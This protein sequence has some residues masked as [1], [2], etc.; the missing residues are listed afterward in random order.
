MAHSIGAGFN[1]NLLNGTLTLPSHAR[2]IEAGASVLLDTNGDCR[3]LAGISRYSL[4]LARAPFC[5]DEATQVHFARALASRL[6]AHVSSIGVHLTGALR[7]DLGFFGFGTAFQPTPENERAAARLLD[8]LTE[9]TQREVLLEN[10]NFYDSGPRAALR[11]LEAQERLTRGRNVALILDLAHLVMEAHN[12]GTDPQLLLGAVPLERVKIIH[13]SGIVQSPDGVLHDGHQLPVH[14]RVWSLLEQTLTLIEQPITVVIEH[15]DRRWDDAQPE[16]HS[17][18]ERL[19]RLVAAP[20]SPAVKAIDTDRVAI[21]Y[22]ANLVLPHRCRPLYDAI[23]K[24]AF[25]ALVL[26]WGADFLA[27]AKDI[28]ASFVMRPEEVPLFPGRVLDPADDFLQYAA[29][30]L[31]C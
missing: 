18:H 21:G 27:R 19:A 15:T 1:P 23:G 31:P 24:E 6:P 16:F 7:R 17:D 25:K 11:V 5:E 22:M 26:S 2:Y 13:L 29:R 14:A 3:E 20:E 28:D 12:V 8:L 30:S 9:L 4:H 10:A